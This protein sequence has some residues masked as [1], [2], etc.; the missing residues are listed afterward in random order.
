MVE[1]AKLQRQFEDV[2]R[3]SGLTRAAAEED[4]EEDERLRLLGGD[5]GGGGGDGRRDR[6][7]GRDERAGGSGRGAAGGRGGGRDG[8]RGGR[9]G[10]GEEERQR[11][12]L[13]AQKRELRDLQ[14]Q[15]DRRAQ[16]LHATRFSSERSS[17]HLM[18]HSA[19]SPRSRSLKGVSCAPVSVPVSV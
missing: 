8:G 13:G 9:G 14:R 11:R 18:T 1:V 10:G 17:E 12:R 5:A 16:P 6:R 7:D 3:S 4:A 19:N 15:R 2:L